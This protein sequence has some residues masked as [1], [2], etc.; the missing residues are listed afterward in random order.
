MTED[1][2]WDRSGKASAEETA[3][4]AQL[5]RYRHVRKPLPKPKS[6]WWIY[7][8]AASLLLGAWQFWPETNSDWTMNGKALAVNRM[9]Q[10]SE[11]AEV[12]VG[13]IGRV[14]FEAGSRFKILESGPEPETH[15]DLQL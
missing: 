4:E 14:R 15:T 7:A 5:G 11:K 2:L 12:E 13:S 9:I 6:T 8:T 10:L 1:Y 3:L